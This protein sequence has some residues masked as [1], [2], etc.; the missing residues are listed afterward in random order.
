MGTASLTLYIYIFFFCWHITEHIFGTDGTFPFVRQMP[1]DRGPGEPSTSGEEAEKELTSEDEII[2]LLN[3][4]D[5]YSVWGL[6]RRGAIDTTWLKREYR[7]KVG[8]RA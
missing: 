3:C 8:G 2:R 7:K 1:T 4:P 6:P 5:H